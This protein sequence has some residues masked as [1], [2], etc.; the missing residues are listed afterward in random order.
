[1]EIKRGIPVSPGVAIGPALVLHTEGY[2]IPQRFIDA[3][4][5]PEEIKRLRRALSAAAA[6]AEANQRAVTEKL[7]AHYGAIFGAHALLVEDA[8]LARELESLIEHQHFAAEYAVSQVIR[9][10]A[11]ALE[12]IDRG[13][14]ATRA[15]DFFDI[16]R[17]ILGHLLGQQRENVHDLKQPVIIVARD[18]TPSE[19]AAMDRRM[20][21]AFAT[22][23][24]GRAS[25]TA[26]MAGALEIPAVVGLG[27][28][29]TGVSGGD[30]LIVDANEGVVILDP[31]EQTLRLYESTQSSFRKF[32]TQ[33]GE[34]RDFPAETRA[35]I[36]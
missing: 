20:V 14:F 5:V 24:G 12:S 6:E 22:E 2:R 33:L 29:V 19:T 8:T 15:A 30:L 36:Y 35:G 7:G 10:Y 17:S 32:E 9:R 31:D 26:I 28:F 3:K 13:H 1:M 34:L 11:K 23:A 21:H 18:L 16:E 27:K 4:A 25:H